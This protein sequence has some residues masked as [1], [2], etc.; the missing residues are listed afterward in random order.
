MR[1]LF[2]VLSVLG[3]IANT[4]AYN[5]IVSYPLRWAGGEV[6]LVLQLDDTRTPDFLS[7][8]NTSWDDVAM[9]AVAIWNSVLPTIQFSTT[10]GPGHANGNERNEIFFSPSIY[11]HRFGRG[12]L[13]VT[14]TWHI[15][16]ERVEGDTIFN[17]AIPWDSYR[18]ELQS[19]SVDFRR[20]AIHEFGHIVGLGHP[21]QARQ[22]MVSVMNSIISDLDTIANDDVFGAQAL[23]ATETRHV[24]NVAVD[25][26][27]AG[28]VLVKP[29]APDGKMAR[30]ALAA[31]TPKPNRGFRFNF[32]DAPDPSSSRVLKFR[33]YEDRDIT[34]HFSSNTAPR[35]I[36]H[37]KSQF[38]SV[39]DFVTFRIKIANAR[40]ASFQ[41]QFEGT[42]I[43]GATE[44]ALTLQGAQHWDSGLYSVTVRTAKGETQ[45]K[46]A[47]LVVDDY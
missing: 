24:I 46:P 38:A 18:G 29:T 47:R 21:D 19:G 12:V 30:G 16:D 15:G 33:A 14:T 22:V 36:S 43:P 13:A 6:P 10:S 3:I 31:L 8:G 34:A 44:S 42:D 28:V 39:E 27:Q 37:P 20:V 41:W 25:P 17:S 9:E 32:W 2:V 5:F 11:G 1:K 26:P 40:Q 23:Y 35:I 4:R 45:S 7:D